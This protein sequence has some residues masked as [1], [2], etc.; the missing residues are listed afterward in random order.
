MNLFSAYIECADLSML[1]ILACCKLVSV[2][3]TS[4]VC[5]QLK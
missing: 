4:T 2:V 3:E 5:G 1:E